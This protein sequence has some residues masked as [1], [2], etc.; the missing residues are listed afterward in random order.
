MRKEVPNTSAHLVRSALNQPEG[1]P[2]GSIEIA[3]KFCSSVRISFRVFPPVS[4][5]ELIQPACRPVTP[6]YYSVRVRPDYR[7]INPTV[8]AGSAGLMGMPAIGLSSTTRQI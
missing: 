4:H 3:A 7:P 2:N 6:R 5:T 1:L 8:P